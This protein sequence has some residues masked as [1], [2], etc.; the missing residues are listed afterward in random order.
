MA[1]QLSVSASANTLCQW[2][3]ARRLVDI[4]FHLYRNWAAVVGDKVIEGENYRGVPVRQVDAT[5][6]E[7]VLVFRQALDE[8]GPHVVTR[9]R[10]TVAGGGCEVGTF[11][12]TTTPDGVCETMRVLLETEEFS[13]ADPGGLVAERGPVRFPRV[14][15]PGNPRNP[16]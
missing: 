7:Q 9:L 2:A 4:A 6:Q 15:F 13:Y 11:E 10:L 3:D 5:F 16:T 14:V 8:A 1:D 12:L